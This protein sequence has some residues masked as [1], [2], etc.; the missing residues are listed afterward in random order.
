VKRHISDF[1]FF[2]GAP[3]FSK[4]LVV[5]RPN[6]G[7]PKTFMAQAEAIMRSGILSNHGPTVRAFEE[8]LA[9]RTGVLH[10]IA[11]CNATVALEVVVRAMDLCGEV[12]VP[13]FTFIATA[14]AL[15]R[16]GVTP[17]FCDVDPV[18]HCLDPRHVEA[19][20]TARTSGVLAVNLWGQACAID[21]LTQLCQ[22]R[23]V[24][25][26]FDSAHAFGCSFRGTPLGGFGDAEVFS[27]HATKVL[28]TGEGG[29][30]MTRNDELAA[31]CAR[32]INFGLEDG[33]TV[34]AL[35]TNGKMQELA[36]ALGLTNL[37]RYDDF[38]A[39]NRAN[40]EA[41]HR[42]LNSTRGVRLLT[43]DPANESNLHYVV[44]E[45]EEDEI[46][47][48]RDEIM[49]VLASENIRSRRYFFPG[50]H[51]AEPY[52]SDRRMPRPLVPNTERLARN[53]LVMPTG[54]AASVADVE[55]AC[56]ALR[57][58]VENGAELRARLEKASVIK[59]AL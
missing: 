37:E 16:A 40:D 55:T 29:C 10:C 23:G 54:M 27:F 35:G 36:A 5:G 48:S 46:G 33:D 58:L 2:G 59:P 15:R 42:C 43:R 56:D 24:R 13:S 41:Y 18:T 51:A 50:C 30:I 9:Q 47:A 3:A 1:A 39:A 32:M 22:R 31:R 21:E 52:R 38:V 7:E 4:P 44:L 34:A 28:N 26:L 19:L 20:I 8:V 57:F 25:L 49:R 14:H 11:T 12:I 17:V 53:V 45:F 6:L